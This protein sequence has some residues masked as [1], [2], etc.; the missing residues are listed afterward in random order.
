MFKVASLVFDGDVL[1]IS[2]D[3]LDALLMRSSHGHIQNR[4]RSGVN[5]RES[6]G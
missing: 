5:R 1:A 2:P 3:A 4:E 6:Y